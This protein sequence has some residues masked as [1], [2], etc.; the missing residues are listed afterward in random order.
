MNCTSHGRGT[1][2][3]SHTLLTV[4]DLNNPLIIVQGCVIIVYDHT[5]TPIP[6]L[7]QS[8]TLQH[9]EVHTPLLL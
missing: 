7:G 6:I 8:Y 1:I 2:G 5:Y 4:I 3:N 9:R